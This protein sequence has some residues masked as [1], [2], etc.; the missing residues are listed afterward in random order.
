MSPHSTSS[1]ERLEEANLGRQILA[2][3]G[4]VDRRHREGARGRLDVGDGDARL[5][6]EGRVGDR[7]A[8]RGE[9][10]PHVERD[11][12]VA[13]HAVPYAEIAG[14]FADLLGQVIGRDLDLLEAEDVGAFALDEGG[15]LV[16]ARADAV[17]VPGDDLHGLPSS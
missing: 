2:A 16:A 1:R 9:I 10:A 8:R 3:V 4:Y 12:G 5:V 11:A 17:D 13:L 7:G 14:H 15:D 6:V